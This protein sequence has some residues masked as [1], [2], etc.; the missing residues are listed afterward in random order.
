[1]NPDEE[2][3]K[4]DDRLIL[5]KQFLIVFLPLIALMGIVLIML[6][7]A[8][9]KTERAVLE[10]S[11]KINVT[12]EAEEITHDFGSVITDLMYLSKAHE[13]LQLINDKG[14]EH[15]DLRDDFVLFSEQKGIYDQIRFLDK[16][17]MEIIRVNYKDKKSYTVQKDELQSKADRDYFK[18]AIALNKDEIYISPFELNIEK[19]K[20]EEPRKPII[21]FG[22][23][24]FSSSGQ[25]KGVLF[26]NYLGGR[27]L[28]KFSETGKTPDDKCV[29]LN[30]DGYW[31][32]SDNP[33]DEFGFMYEGKKDRTFGN[34]YP[35]EWERI[36]KSDSGQF[37][38]AKGLF[39]FTKVYPFLEPSEHGLNLNLTKLN[40]DYH[41]IIVSQFSLSALN[42]V[43]FKIFS[44]LI[45]VFAGLAIILAVG[46]LFFVRVSISRRQAE[47]AFKESERKIR[48]ITDSAQDA[49]IMIDNNGDISYWNDAALKIFGYSKEEVIKR[50][51]HELIIP[52]RYRD[53]HVKAFER[54]R[55]TGKGP[56][57]GRTLELVAIRK[58]GDEFPVEIAISTVNIKGKWSAIGIVR[59]ITKRKL[60]EESLRNIALGVVGAS[61]EAVFDSLATYLSK[62]LRSDYVLIG[63]TKEGKK[64]AVQTIAVCANGE[65]IDNF[66]YDL[67]GS[68][69]EP[70]VETGAYFCPFDAQ[71]EFPNARHLAEWGIESFVGAPLV[72]MTGHTIGAMVI[73]GRK[74]LEDHNIAEAML[75]IFAVRATAELERK[76]SEEK[77]TKSYQHQ[78]ALN[79]LLQVSFE[80]TSLEEL[81]TRSLDI[82]LSL[83]WLKVLSKG[84][85]FLVE[86]EP[87]TLILK[88]YRGLSKE[89]SETCRRVP[90]GKCLC[91]KAAVSGGIEFADSIT[92]GHTIHYNGMEPHGHYCV[93]ILTEGQVIGVINLYLKEGHIRK[94]N[95]VT[96]L[97]AV[98]NTLAALIRRKQAEEKL[99][100][101]TEDLRIAKE[102]QEENSKRLS[103]VVEELNVA[104]KRAEE[105]TSAKSEFLANMSHEIRTPMN[106]IIGMVDLLMETDMTPEQHDFA[107]TMQIS[108][109][110][111]LT[112]INDILDFSKIEAGKLTLESIPFD[113]KIVAENVANLLA[114]KAEENGI[115]LILRYP[116]S[117]PRFIIGDPVRVRQVLTNLASNSIK[118]TQKG[119]VLINIESEESNDK[120]ALIKM[121]V[122]D[123]GIGISKDRMEYIFEKFSQADASTT[124]KFGGTGLGL[125]ISNKLV[126]MMGGQMGVESNEGV[127]STFYFTGSFPLDISRKAAPLDTVNLKDIRILVICENDIRCQVLCEKF[128]EWGMHCNIAHLVG[129][130]L[131]KLRQA[132]ID[133]A[134]FKIAVIDTVI[135]DMDTG[136]LSHAIKADHKLKDTG[137]V[138]LTPAGWHSNGKRMKSD[139]IDAYITKPVYESRLLET[140]SAVLMEEKDEQITRHPLPERFTDESIGMIIKDS[141]RVLLVEDNLVN[142][143]V[144]TRMLEKLNCRVYIANNGKEAV[145]MAGTSF[146]DI[147]F[148]DC[149][150]PEMDGYEATSEIRREE[151][152]SEH[153]PIVAMTAHVMQGAKERCLEAGMDDYI[154]KPIQR[155]KLGRILQKYLSEKITL[156]FV[157]EPVG[158]PEPIESKQI[159]PPVNL[160]HIKEIVEDDPETLNELIN[161]YLDDTA[162][163]MAAI[164]SAV[165]KKDAELIKKEAHSMKGASA[166]IGADRMKK[167]CASLEKIGASGDIEPAAGILDDLKSE[168]KQVKKY[169]KSELT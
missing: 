113:L 12:L 14:F 28:E 45:K 13:L 7:R 126:R 20:I 162:H 27:L 156:D 74:P 52:E 31:L 25:R 85:I 100:Q 108:A 43:S 5:L 169:L 164:E 90:F 127:G 66:E 161:I 132:H 8:D 159:E 54:F 64:N 163:H 88:G 42:A 94:K 16:T 121:G 98:A 141:I 130:A 114:S 30:S 68:P 39:T 71:K 166:N 154:S 134:P 151:S 10:V 75:Q 15:E 91:G 131:T 23:P 105:A 92:P 143:K 48:A 116:S 9:V 112:I 124:R 32:K 65:I 40:K 22:T 70:G 56:V 110:A 1:M 102:E 117:V 133:D 155:K 109:E 63:E 153:I 69:L 145:L 44:K 59:D 79:S 120:E 101:Y 82:I 115:E 123:T 36:L 33:E 3:I 61:S 47:V 19:G 158:I 106:G 34:D 4:R 144:A 157:P 11:Q 78:I 80:N 129:E 49:I 26:F 58:C 95:E 140:L 149:Q 37:Y 53:E 21:R 137:I 73:L 168:F 139:E 46:V 57:I 84:S 83:P 165:L 96:F 60:S 50:K 103:L 150:M 35:D 99:K 17:G 136:T 24:L 119:Y 97:K 41:W 111:L 67:T 138:M 55:L 87:E 118:F 93:P 146:Y 142:Q 128:S 2:K 86:D 38:T 104:K 29:L 89:I 18:K 76:R 160:S 152:A 77:V 122:K 6:Y 72:D 135:S 125:S 147:I 51:I 62:A 81:L 167:Y 107:K 148:M